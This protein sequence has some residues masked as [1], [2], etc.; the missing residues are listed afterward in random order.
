MWCDFRSRLTDS[1]SSLSP[2]PWSRLGSEGSAHLRDTSLPLVLIPCLVVG[3]VGPQPE[4]VINRTGLAIAPAP[5]SPIYRGALALYPG[6]SVP[7]DRR[8]CPPSGCDGPSCSTGPEVTST[9]HHRPLNDDI[10]LSYASR[11]FS[12]R[13]SRQVLSGMNSDEP[14]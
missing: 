12:L 8:Q 2:E 9:R 1:H 6:S 7:G 5:R 10:R 14:S 13:R 4:A 3:G 11:G